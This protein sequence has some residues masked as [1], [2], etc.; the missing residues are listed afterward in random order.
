MVDGELDFADGVEAVAEEE[1]VVLVDRAA[2]GVFHGENCVISDPEL[3]RLK[4]HLK[5]VAR[6]GLAVRVRFF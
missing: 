1:V 5:L 6:Y 4:R 3:H 2:K